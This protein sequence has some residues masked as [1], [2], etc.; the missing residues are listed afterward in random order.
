MRPLLTITWHG[1]MMVPVW[2]AR[3]KNFVAMISQ[4]RDGEMVAR[5]VQKLGYETVR[6]SSTRGGSGAAK[7]MVERLKNGQVGAMICDGPKGPIYKMKPGT[8]YIALTAGAEVIP[9]TFAGKSRWT[10]RSWDRFT[11]PKPFSRV[12][13]L[14]GEPIPFPGA[15]TDVNKFSQKLEDALNDLTAQADALAAGKVTVK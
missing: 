14:W 13:L 5:L 12:F 3:R 11:V 4:H 10:F 1:R 7:L 15:D 6:G 2:F 9:A 8:P